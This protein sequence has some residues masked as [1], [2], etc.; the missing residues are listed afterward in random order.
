MTHTYNTV[1]RTYYILTLL[2]TLAA[3]FI[4]G[5]NTL[6]LLDAGLSNTEAFAANA[7]FTL[8]QVIFEIP[9]GLIAD[10]RGRK[11]SFALG[12][13]TLTLSTLAYFWLW[14][15][16]GP[17]WAWAIVSLLL[18]LGFSFFSGATE[19][20]LVDALHFTGY[21]ESL[22]GV[23]A[24]GQALGGAAMLIGSVGGGLIAQVTNL[25]VPYILRA[26][27]LAITFIVCLFLMHDMGFTPAKNKSYATQ[28]KST[29][30]AATTLGW[31]HKPVR[32]IILAGPFGGVGIYVFY[33]TQPYLLQLYGK[34]DAYAIAGI[35]AAVVAGAQILGGLL[36]PK[37][38]TLFK[39]RTGALI[40]AGIVNVVAITLLGLIH[41]FWAAIG[42]VTVTGL[43]FALVMPLTQAY[44]NG[45]IPSEQRATMLSIASLFDSGGGAITQPLLG[46]VAD[47]RGYG[48]SYLVSAAI[49]LGSLPFLFL[50]RKQKAESDLIT[51]K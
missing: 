3:S 43:T 36:V 2:S 12:A 11:L 47:S 49:E 48:A 17:F 29:F 14:Q 28:L 9:T 6:F 23:F 8:G 41:N 10:I 30:A 15:T 13:I 37:I 20:W 51:N 4:W 25:G 44:I 33:A 18:G 16:H 27:V 38:R 34:S 40:F 5:I 19:A 32:W 22:E 1:K 35:V 26:I 31:K 50:A 39:T 45:L 7:F 42:L 46:R 24:K 21:K